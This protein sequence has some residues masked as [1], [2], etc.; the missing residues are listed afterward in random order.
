MRYPGVTAL[1]LVLGCGSSDSSQGEAG[2]ICDRLES[3]LPELFQELT[4]EAQVSCLEF[5][6]MTEGLGKVSRST[7][8]KLEASVI[9]C[10]KKAS[11]CNAMKA[12]LKATK[13]QAAVCGQDKADRCSG[14]ILVECDGTPEPDAFD[15]AAAGLKCI[16]S[17]GDARCAESDCQVPTAPSCDGDVK[18]TCKDGALVLEDCR[19]STLLSCSVSVGGA[20]KCILQGGGTC[21]ADPQEGPLCTGTGADCDPKT[22]A[23]K[24]EGHVLVACAGG[25]EARLDCSAID[26]ALTCK[27]T[28][29]QGVEAFYCGLP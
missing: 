1:I 19:F 18:K 17:E 29:K 21:V 23:P 13:D 3:C 22:F 15:C 2:A 6:L 5:V 27:K 4:K 7:E 14:N 25:K 12:C 16:A 8:A 24:C 9:G 20:G 28:S 26:P 11:D 10:L